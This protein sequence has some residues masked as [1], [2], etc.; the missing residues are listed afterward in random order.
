MRFVRCGGYCFLR[1]GLLARG[2][3]GQERRE[4]LRQCRLFRPFRQ[5]DARRREASE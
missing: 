1:S 3:G 5:I 4:D 2:A